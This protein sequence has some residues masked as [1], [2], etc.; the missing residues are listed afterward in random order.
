MN[1]A[2][3]LR[4]AGPANALI[5]TLI[6]RPQPP[7]NGMPNRLLRDGGKKIPPDQRGGGI[8]NHKLCQY[9]RS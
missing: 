5:M 2:M 6:T 1:L 8:L 3:F 7:G 9:I 4:L